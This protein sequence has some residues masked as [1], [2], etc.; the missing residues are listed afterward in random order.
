MW[1]GTIAGVVLGLA[2]FVGLAAVW[3]D[4]LWYESLSQGSV[5]WIRIA[6]QALVWCGAAAVG[7]AITFL[8]A[9]AAWRSVAGKPRFNSLTALACFVLAGTMAWTISQSWMVFRLAAAQAPFGITDPQFGLDVGFFVFTLPALELLNSWLIGLCVL[10]MVLVVAIAFVSTRLDTTGEIRVD[11]WRLKKT[12][13]VLI[14][15]LM[16]TAAA[17][18]LIAIYRVSF[19]VAETPFV[20]A[21]YADVHA[22]IP[23]YWILLGLSIVVAVALFATA[24]SKRFKPVLL[25]FGVWVA[26]ALLLGSLWPLLVQ[27]FIAA[28]NE[29][30]LE[31]PYIARNISMTRTAFDLSSVRSQAYPA[32]TSV[33]ASAAAAAENDLQ[34]ATIWT[35]DSVEQAFNQLQQ[36]RPYYRLSPSEYDRYE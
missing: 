18:Y 17:N 5:F 25:T 20:G 24:G 33:T 30:T 28:P 23:A 9:R 16:L 36:I 8:A 14:G 15:F 22:T 6:S 13:S 29:A 11:W 12:L 35:P 27:T 1:V 21:S 32:L 19:S 34:D 2:A 26:A 7:F 3:T 10:A 31:A 4:Y